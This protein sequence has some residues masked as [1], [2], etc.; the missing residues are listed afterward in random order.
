[1][2]RLILISPNLLRVAR[3]TSRVVAAAVL[4]GLLTLSLGVHSLDQ[5]WVKRHVLSLVRSTTGID[6][7]YRSVRVGLLSFVDIDD[8]LVRSPARVRGVAPELARI[9][10]VEA[11]WSLGSIFHEGPY[12]SRVTVSGVALTVVI[13]EHG[14]TSFDL[15]SPATGGPP[16]PA[17]PLSHQPASF[18]GKALPIGSIDVRNVTMAVIRTDHGRARDRAKLS[19]VSAAVSTETVP[20]G[21]RIRAHLGSPDAPLALHLT[22]D[23]EGAPEGTLE[24]KLWLTLE[25]SPTLAHVIVDF[26]VLE[27]TFL[28]DFHVGDPVHVEASARFDPVGGKTELTVDRTTVGNGA[29]TAAASVEV[30]DSGAPLVRHAEGD[31]DLA[32]LL[33][34]L[35]PG[36]IPV[37]LERA[38]VRYDIE[39]LVADARPRLSDGGKI[40]LDADL[41]NVK[42]ALTGGAVQFDEAKFTLHGH[43]KDGNIAFQGA[44]EVSRLVSESPPINVD[45]VTV[46][47]DG[48][49]RADR[50][51]EGHVDVR[52]T[53][54]DVGGPSPL[55]AREGHAK[56]QVQGLRVDPQ[57][58]LEAQG[59]V[60]LSADVRSIDVR[61]GRAQAVVDGWAFHAHANLDGRTPYAVDFGTSASRLRA[62]DAEGRMLADAPVRVDARLGDVY[63]NLDRPAASRGTV[64][65]KLSL[66][67]LEATLDSKKDVDAADFTLHLV[68][69]SLAQ[70]R[71]FLPANVANEAPWARI[72]VDVRTTGRVERLTSPNPSVKQSMEVHADGPAFGNVKAKSLT[73]SLHSNGD[74]LRHS[75]DAELHVQGLA[76]GD[77]ASSDDGA[78]LSVSVDRQA[79]SLHIELGTT[80]LATSKGSASLSFDRA[81]RVV[82]YD[83]AGSLSG[84]SP[85]AKAASMSRGFDGFDL[86]KV[87]LSFAAQGELLGAVSTLTSDGILVPAPHFTRTAGIEGTADWKA[88]DLNFTS[89]GTVL[90]IPSAEWRGVFHVAGARRTVES[91]LDVGSFHLVAG[92]NRLDVHGLSDRASATVTGDLRDPEAEVADRLSI[93]GVHQDIVPGYPTGNLSFTLAAER[94]SEG[95]VHVSDL[96][97]VNGDGGTTLALTGAI[98]LAARRHR[99]SISADLTQELASLSRVPKLFVGRGLVTLDATVESPD[100]ALFRTRVDL[101]ANDVHAQVPLEGVDVESVDA[102]IPITMTLEVRR[103]TATGKLSVNIRHDEQ[104]NPYSMLR[105]ADQH[106]LISRTGFL[107]IDRVK[108]RLVSIAPLVGN[109]AVEQNVMS[110]RQFEM[111]IRGGRVTGQ[112][113]LDWDGPK[114]T[115]VFHVRATGVRST[116]G[117]PFDGNMAVAF[118]AS[119]R[120]V[121]GRA[122]IVR[123]GPR[124]LLDLLDMQDPMH[125]DPTMN[126]VRTALAFGYPDRMR[127]VFQHGFVSAKLELGGLASLVSIDEIRGIPMG[128]IVDHIM[129]RIRQASRKS[130]DSEKDDEE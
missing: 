103:D 117:E 71:P 72:A 88:S 6:L 62:S 94:D 130:E 68:A 113:A 96:K 85:L 78:T 74:T 12:I 115:L 90:A 95:V 27:Q 1:M 98:D 86:S 3:W 97:L 37:S 65:G 30:P 51:M 56:L 10:H 13:D 121:E 22:V 114:S 19:G 24:A 16:A 38:R 23:R 39:S 92:P 29:A 9:G 77:G 28:A 60:A 58:P 82:K 126:R 20:K 15:L 44:T 83:V 87:A 18:L 5:P 11:R 80:G 67:Q 53:R 129:S 124:H 47:F 54:L 42:V 128:P 127:L 119:D 21:S 49:P 4:L 116:H 45:H 79:P 106:P 107:S 73:L 109:L 81:R 105:F 57:K 52:F 63:P 46:G 100:L 99:L 112:C 120:T 34:C 122:D 125:V 84:L 7:D 14:T 36:L 48:E 108:T 17:V 101:K 40:D 33:R 2:R 8:I 123:I 76:V 32:L 55:G 50:A 70:V 102:K 41:A 26:R 110:L 118:S 61:F 91:H 35:P 43:A 75:A 59:D 66:G 64:H 25:A 104:H 31:M 69:A 89:G 93:R 111:G